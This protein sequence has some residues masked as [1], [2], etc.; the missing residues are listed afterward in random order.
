[1]YKND[2]IPCVSGLITETL[3]V[4][5]QKELQNFLI[6][7]NNTT[8]KNY[9][10][11]NCVKTK[12]ISVKMRNECFCFFFKHVA[13]ESLWNNRTKFKINITIE[14]K[15]VWIYMLKKEAKFLVIF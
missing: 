5:D 3:R 1:M 14:I 13:V 9:G 4:A 12:I 2:R 7:E 6:N 10:I 8:N 15:H 11:L